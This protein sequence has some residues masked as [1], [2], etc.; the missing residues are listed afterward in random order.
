MAYE[1]HLN[2]GNGALTT[3]R[4]RGISAL[5]KP[6]VEQPR[7]HFY[8]LEAAEV[9]DVIVNDDHPLFESYTDIGKIKARKV[10]CP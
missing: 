2:K 3:K 4:R 6:R 9:L 5:K 10:N 8:E 1:K 7:I